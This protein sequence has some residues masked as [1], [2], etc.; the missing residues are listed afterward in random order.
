MASLPMG[1]ESG[2]DRP[3]S[4]KPPFG[5][6]AVTHSGVPGYILFHDNRHPAMMGAEEVGRFLTSLAVDRRLSAS[7]Q[8]Q[9]LSALS[10]PTACN[11]M[12][13]R[14]RGDCAAFA[15]SGEPRSGERGPGREPPKPPL[16]RRSRS[17]ISG[18]SPPPSQT[19]IQRTVPR[20]TRIP[21]AIGRTKRNMQPFL[22]TSTSSWADKSVALKEDTLS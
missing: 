12:F 7:S 11:E 15:R 20:R 14:E 19:P 3:F 2:F 9:A 22:R 21:S 8:N 16:G 10:S 5:P 18:S 13:Q 4:H 1:S 6:P 17:P